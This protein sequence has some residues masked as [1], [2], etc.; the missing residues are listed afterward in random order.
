MVDNKRR[1]IF[2]EFLE[3]NDFY[4][5]YNGEHYTLVHES[6]AIH[7]SNTS[8][9]MYNFVLGFMMNK[10]KHDELVLNL[11]EQN[12]TNVQRYEKI[13]SEYSGYSP[14]KPYEPDDHEEHEEPIEYD[15]IEDFDDSRGTIL[16]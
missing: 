16:A 14:E 4:I 2:K 11:I 9:E 8:D 7:F 5:D 13:I 10:K 6:E 1:A 12:D 15:D 3:D